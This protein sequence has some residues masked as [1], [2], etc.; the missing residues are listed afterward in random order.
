MAETQPNRPLAGHELR[1]IILNDVDNILSQ[2]GMLAS[3][4]AY[5]RAAYVVTV[6]VMTDNPMITEGSWTTETRSKTSTP[7]Q[8][9][10]NESLA[11]IETFP[12]AG[13]RTD[14]ALD[15]GIERGRQI[16]SPNVSRIDNELPVTI[17]F[18]GPDGDVQEDEVIYDK[19]MV[20]E[21]N[22]FADIVNQRELSSEETTRG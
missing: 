19:D 4:I 15:I 14:N 3:H 22:E 18:R 17:V 11:A 6:K 20:P 5:K 7:Q 8:I 21:D 10:N 13:E 12:L 9:E 2:D 16:Q 1:K